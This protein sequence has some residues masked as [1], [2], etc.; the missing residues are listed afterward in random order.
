MWKRLHVKYQ[1]FLSDS[2]KNLNSLDR[3]QKKLKY[4]ISSKSVQWEPSCSMRT[5]MTKLIVAFRNSANAPKNCYLVKTDN[6]PW[7]EFIAASLSKDLTNLKVNIRKWITKSDILPYP[8]YRD[9]RF[10]RQNQMS[11]F[12]ESGEFI[13]KRGD[14]ACV[15]VRLCN[16]KET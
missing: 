6:T 9:A 2:N 15:N 14:F 7:S 3:F 5:D 10:W 16:W 8:I 12:T 1:L 11:Y 4:Q 13:H